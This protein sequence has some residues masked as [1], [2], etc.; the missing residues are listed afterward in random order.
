M[1]DTLSV[2]G[3]HRRGDLDLALDLHLGRGRIAVVGPNGSGKSSLLRLIAGLDAID[4]GEVVIDGT[5]VDR[6][7]DAT[8]VPPED[9]DIG[10]TF[11]NPRLFPHLHALHRVRQP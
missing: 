6:R 5:V 2:A 8:F 7:R 1:A 9:R 10:V 3:R 4:E 11:Q